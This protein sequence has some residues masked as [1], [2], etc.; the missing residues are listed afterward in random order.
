M[1]HAFSFDQEFGSDLIGSSCSHPWWRFDQEISWLCLLKYWPLVGDLN[2]PHIIFPMHLLGCPSHT[3][4][5]FLTRKEATLVFVDFDSCHVLPL[6]Q[7]ST[8][9]TGHLCSLSMK[10]CD[11]QGGIPETDWW[12]AGYHH[13]LLIWFYSLRIHRSLTTFT[14]FL[15]WYEL[16]PIPWCP[17]SYRTLLPQHFQ[18]FSQSYFN[19]CPNQTSS[20]AFLWGPFRLIIN[21]LFY[22]FCSLSDT[23]LIASWFTWLMS[24]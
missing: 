5:H 16:L 9:P 24:S 7:Y 11:Y 2:Y 19:D 21:I 17:S 15:S 22:P 8:G 3:W 10:G 4:L 18:G 23:V 14:F 12:E 1:L 13:N 20:T 6:F